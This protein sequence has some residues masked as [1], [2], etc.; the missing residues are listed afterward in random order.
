MSAYLGNAVPKWVADK[1]IIQVER[2][3]S[4][5]TLPAKLRYPADGT[6]F[7]YFFAT[8]LR[9]ENSGNVDL[10]NEQIDVI[11]AD[12]SMDCGIIKRSDHRIKAYGL[13]GI[14]A[15]DSDFDNFIFAHDASS[16]SIYLS[17][18]KI[19]DH[20]VF[21]IFSNFAFRTALLPVD[22]ELKIATRTPIKPDASF[23]D[24]PWKLTNCKHL[25]EVGADSNASNPSPQRI[26]SNG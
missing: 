10:S 5:K 17:D 12:S 18:L 4:N 3:F 25:Q 22:K 16:A 21:L 15:F 26:G 1:K 20:R 19:G 8:E 9:I 11:L 24:D 6:R 13:K 14:K 23:E 7:P 2:G